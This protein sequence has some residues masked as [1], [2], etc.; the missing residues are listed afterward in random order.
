MREET[1]GNLFSAQHPISALPHLL[2]YIL[3]PIFLPPPILRGSAV[4]IFMSASAFLQKEYV[5]RE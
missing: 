5:L 3:P 1:P 4:T 2:P